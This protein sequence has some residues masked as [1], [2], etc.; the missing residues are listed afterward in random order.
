MLPSVGQF[1]IWKN[2][3]IPLSL[4]FNS[5]TKK[6]GRNP[7]L[8][9]AV[10][11]SWPKVISHFSKSYHEAEKSCENRWHAP[12]RIPRVRMK[13]RNG[14]AQPRV[15]F[16]SAVGCNHENTWRLERKFPR[17]NQLAVIET[18]F[19]RCIFW[20]FDH[21]MPVANKHL[22]NEFTTLSTSLD[23]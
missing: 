2:V 21:V 3:S 17:E 15:Y 22:K 6:S 1:S 18:A 10:L 5:S 16:E 20:T 14:E 12:C 4:K 11:S 13:V 8:L 23:S 7:F 19:V 9:N